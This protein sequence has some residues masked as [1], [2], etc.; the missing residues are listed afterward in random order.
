MANTFTIRSLGVAIL[1]H[2]MSDYA[3]QWEPEG[4]SQTFTAGSPVVAS[5]GLLVAAT[6][7]IETDTPNKLAG[8]AIEDGH[9]AAAGVSNLC[10]FIPV[11]D[12]VICYANLL[13]GDGATNAFAAA[14]LLNDG[15]SALRSKS[16]LITTGVTDWFLDDA[17]ANG[18]TIVSLSPD[19]IEPNQTE[20]RVTDTDN[21]ARVGFVFVTG[22]RTY[23]DS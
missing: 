1:H 22:V 13:T 12:G 14:D 21:D 7:P 19:I 4:A 20:P 23:P 6:S 10:K 9:N 16:G 17:D 5:S 15:A 18:C 3:A 2:P 11:I 8:I